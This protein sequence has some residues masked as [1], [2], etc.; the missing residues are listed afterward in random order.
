MQVQ[1]EGKPGSNA[2]IQ[3]DHFARAQHT[4]FCFFLLVPIVVESVYHVCFSPF[5][6]YDWG[7]FSPLP[8]GSSRISS[9]AN[10]GEFNAFAVVGSVAGGGGGPSVSCG[11]FQTMVPPFVLA[12]WG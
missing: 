2:G 11:F 7:T 1:L 9:L 12:K 3:D 4:I 10:S 8:S 6:V 5:Y